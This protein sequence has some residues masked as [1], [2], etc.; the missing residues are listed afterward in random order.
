MVEQK[1]LNLLV[2]GSSPT[3]STFFHPGFSL[4]NTGKAF[5][6]KLFGRLSLMH[7]DAPKCAKMPPIL[8]AFGSGFRKLNVS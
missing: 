3:R 8:A 7:A 2:V 6:H 5:K 4:E 1:T